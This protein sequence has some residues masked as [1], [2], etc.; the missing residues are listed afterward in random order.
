MDYYIFDW[1]SVRN[2]VTTW[3]DINAKKDVTLPQST[4]TLTDQS[5]SSADANI[6]VDDV[7]NQI[8]VTDQLK[9]SDTLITSPLDGKKLTSIFSGKVK[10]MTEY[11]SEEKAIGL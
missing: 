3:Y 9:S 1:D 7:Y 5:F 6:T 10:Y 4:V 11:I 2:K 8:Q